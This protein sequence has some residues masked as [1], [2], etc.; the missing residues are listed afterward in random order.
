MNALVYHGPNTMR[1]EQVPTPEPKAHEVRLRIRAVGICGSDLHGYLGLTGRRTPPMVMGHEFTGEVEKLGEGVSGLRV[2]DRVSCYPV[3]FC[4]ACPKCLS[5][6]QHLCESRRQFGV[7]SENGAM[8]DYLCVPEKTCFVLADDVSF[9]VGTLMEPLAVSYR[10]VKQAGNLKDKNVLVA[11]AGTIGLLALACVIA[12]GPASVTVTD[13]SGTRLN[14][15]REMGATHVIDPANTD[16]AKQVEAITQ[17]KG[18]DVAIEAVGASATVGQTIDALQVGG[19]AIWIGNNQPQVQVT[20]QKVVTRELRIYGS[21]LYS[22]VEFM[23]VM[24]LVNEHKLRVAPLI[25]RVEPLEN[26]AAVFEELSR[27]VGNTIK[28]VLRQER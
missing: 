3:D 6:Q 23:T 26:G 28:C 14:V 20:M 21:F 10:A 4:G 13:L 18:M 7:L 15:A 24:K 17:G 27:N 5:N 2:G 12:Q 25:N 9:E 19:T 16:F 11:G 8:A 22:L 1:Y